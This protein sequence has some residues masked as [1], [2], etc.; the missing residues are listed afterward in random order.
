MLYFYHNYQVIFITL[1]K[2]VHLRLINLTV[3]MTRYIVGNKM[4]SFPDNDVDFYLPQL[5]V[6]YIQLHDVT[7]VLYPYLVHR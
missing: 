4:F 5:V 1:F 2:Y 3:N 6:M 7:E